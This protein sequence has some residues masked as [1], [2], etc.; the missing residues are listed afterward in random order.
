MAAIA[1]SFAAA[2]DPADLDALRSIARKRTFPAGSTMLLEGDLSASVLLVESGRVK[3]SSFTED[4]REIVLALRDAGDLLGE[5]SVLDGEPLSATAAALDEVSASAIPAEAFK[6]F[7]RTHA[8]AS[9]ALLEIVS[10]RL[11]DADRKRIEFGAYDSI[12]RVA[13]RLLELADRFGEPDGDGVLIPLPLSQEEIAGWTGS[14][15]E[16]V[17]KAL[18]TLRERGLVETG[19]KEIRIFDIATLRKR[20]T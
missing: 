2:L 18:R 6:E 7:L 1:G 11:R 16:A 5:L 10:R 17:S 4:G 12:G 15:R 13:R 14:S 9:L 20:A 8:A 19:R 3:I